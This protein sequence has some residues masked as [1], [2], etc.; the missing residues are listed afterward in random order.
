MLPVLSLPNCS[1]YQWYDYIVII[2]HLFPQSRLR[3][4]MIVW[5]SPWSVVRNKVCDTCIFTTLL[6]YNV[7]TFAIYVGKVSYTYQA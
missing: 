5:I 2:N 6:G 4:S 7:I 3:D 1:N